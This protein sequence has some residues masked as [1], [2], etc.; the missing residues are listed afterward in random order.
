MSILQGDGRERFRLPTRAVTLFAVI[1]A[2]S[3]S[4]SSSAPTPLYHFYQQS[5]GLSNLTVTTIFAAYALT[6]VATFLT[7]A[8]L[9]DYIGRRPMIFA[10]L[11]LNAL[12]LVLFIAA[13]DAATLVAARLVQGI[14][15][16]IGMTTLGATILDTDRTN[17]P[18]YNSVTAFLGLTAGALLAGILITSAPLPTRLVFGILLAVTAIEGLVLLVTPETSSAKPG[19]MRVLLPQIAIPQA[20]MPTMARLLPLNVATWS[21]GGFY[22]S[23]MPTLVSV[24][25]GTAS[26]LVGAVMVALLPFTGATT[27]LV[28][29]KVAPR[30]LL[31]L[32]SFALAAGVA[33]TLV[34]IQAQSAAV[35]VVG[36]I[37]A[38]IGFGSSYAGNLRSILPLAREHERAGLLAAYFVESY[39]SFAVPTVLAGLA[40]PVLGLV[41]TSEFY[42]VVL[43]ALALLSVLLR[44][45]RQP[46]P[47]ACS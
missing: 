24:A 9:S 43:I 5:M 26:P 21:L 12:A 6:M 11:A 10:G 16:S 31:P 2:M 15:V 22:L 13:G 29:R 14:A 23:L 28:L 45:I 35:M 19:A 32:A 17:G 4:A 38:G 18:V 42:G 1:T 40:V 39:A 3:F 37:V 30:R 41:E 7:V 27:V 8:R 20:A 36:T 44:G 34:G 33:V 47:A 25:T 46:A